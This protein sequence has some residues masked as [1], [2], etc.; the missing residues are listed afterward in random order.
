MGFAFPSIA[1][2]D[3]QISDN[4]PRSD[5]T[6]ASTLLPLITPGPVRMS[7]P[8]A[9]R[10]LAVEVEPHNRFETLQIR[11]LIDC[12]NQ[13]AALDHFVDLGTGIV[14]G[15]E[16]FTRHHTSFLDVEMQGA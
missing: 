6:M 10:E 1:D 7:P 8:G 2:S 16:Q 9:K 12:L 3:F 13:V 11:L 4:L 15:C 5:S 14:G